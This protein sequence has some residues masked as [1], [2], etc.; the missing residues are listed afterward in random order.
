[1]TFGATT[2]TGGVDS[3]ITDIYHAATGGLPARSRDSNS[4]A[5]VRVAVS[6]GQ[7]DDASG[8]EMLLRFS[9]D[10][11][12]TWSDYFSD[13]MTEGSFYG[14]LAFRSLG[15][16][17]A[18]GRIFELSDFGGPFRIDGADAFVDNFD[19]DGPVVDPPDPKE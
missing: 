17:S 4:V 12:Q 18:P 1:M 7:L 3:S 5:A 16:F 11:E 19:A 14:E 13:I 6:K 10:Y 2:L 9:D 8:S 15:A